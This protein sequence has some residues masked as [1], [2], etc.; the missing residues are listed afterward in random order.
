[1]IQQMFKPILRRVSTGAAAL[2]LCVAVLPAAAALDSDLPPQFIQLRNAGRYQDLARELQSAVADQPQSAL[3]HYWLGRSYYEL[4]DYNRA[5][6]SLERATELEPNRSE[7]QD[8][9][10]KASGRKAEHANPFS[11]MSL[12]RKAFHAF[13]TAVKLAPANIEAQRDLIS[14]LLNAPGVL[15]GGEAAALKQIQDLTAVQPLDGML[16]HAEYFVSRK[17]YD[18]AAAEYERIL[19]MNVRRIGVPLEVADFYRDRGDAAHMQAAV[20]SAISLDPDDPRLEYY[21]GIAQVLGK[22]DYA[23][24]E[25][26]LRAYLQK[27][28]ESSQAPSH[29]SAHEWLGKL[30]EAQG[31]REQAIVEYQLALS[32]DSQNAGARKGLEQLQPR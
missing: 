10:G 13:E 1:M 27:V 15:G 19:K 9:L 31:K 30:Y 6:S 29:S 7:Y 24:A 28:P 14:Y 4:R 17:K 16:A 21:R 22:Q 32:I 18:Q 5:E 11:A 25:K 26:H 8:W 2:L 20:D 12:A 23:G 3:L